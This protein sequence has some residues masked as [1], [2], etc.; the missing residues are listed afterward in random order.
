MLDL[1][2]SLQNYCKLET[3]FSLMLILEKRLVY[4]GVNGATFF[5][6][7]IVGYT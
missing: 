5:V 2:K 6:S 7:M 3:L 1:L 4:K